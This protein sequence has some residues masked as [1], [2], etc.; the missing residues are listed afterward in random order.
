MPPQK[1]PAAAKR[2]ASSK[3]PRTDFS[4]VVGGRAVILF[5]HNL[6]FIKLTFGS[7][8]KMAES[9][10]LYESGSDNGH[11]L[12][13][14]E[15]EASRPL[16]PCTPHGPKVNMLAEILSRP[17]R[18]KHG[19][20]LTQFAEQFEH[21]QAERDRFRAMSPSDQARTHYETDRSLEGKSQD[22]SLLPIVLF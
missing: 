15:D 3:Q 10:I 22:F 6:L 18:C 12:D 1:R 14:D 13:M 20:C 9:V 4:T 7:S 5:A 16:A 17:C 19:S 11:G 21:V 2:P 8:S